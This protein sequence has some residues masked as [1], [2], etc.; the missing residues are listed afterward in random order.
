MI[1]KSVLQTKLYHG[2]HT[3]YIMK[4]ITLAEYGM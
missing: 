3:E 4:A 1:I 2:K